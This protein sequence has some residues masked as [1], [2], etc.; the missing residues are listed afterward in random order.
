MVKS[1]KLACIVLAAGKGTR[2]KSSTPKVLHK[3]ANK[4]MLWHVLNVAKSAKVQEVVTVVSPDGS[5]V[6]KAAEELSSK[7]AVQKKQLGTGDAVLAAKAALK[8]FNG[9]VIILYGDCPL[10]TKEAIKKLLKIREKFDIAVLGFDA[11]EPGSYGRLVTEGNELKE[12]VEAKDATK[13]QKEISLCNSGIYALDA[14]LLFNLLSKVKNNNSKGEYYLTDIV[15]IAA[16]QKIKTGYAVVDEEIVQGVNSKAELADAEA[17]MQER[18]CIKA[19]E[20]GV[21]MTA[22]ETV[23]LSADTKLGKDVT[24]KPNVVIDENVVIGS[25]VSIGPFAHIRPGTKLGNDSK[26]GNFV[27]VKAST[28]SEGAKI[29]HLSY[30]GDAEIGKESNI[31]AGTITCNYDGFKKH[32]TQIGDNVFV[33]SDVALVAPVKLGKGSI[34]GA[35]SII[36]DDVDD[37]AISIARAEQKNLAGRATKYRKT[38]KK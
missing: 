32:K 8:N 17:I 5:Q 30:V 15:K 2:M 13:S 10:I 6:A 7:T 4:T 36:V 28:I 11:L 24:I 38:K 27:E 21:T 29:N 35:G 16:E 18:L 22:P 12:I 33:G 19:L 14:K 3:V 34:I 20:A 37:N 1:N 23:F 25:G 26:I 31:G 9:D